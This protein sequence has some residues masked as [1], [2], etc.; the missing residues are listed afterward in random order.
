MIT[1]SGATWQK[2]EIFS[3][4][5]LPIGISD[6]QTIRSGDKPNPRNSLTLD[7]VGLVLGSPVDFG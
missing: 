4:T 3:L 6:L 5:E 7:C 1:C 2:F